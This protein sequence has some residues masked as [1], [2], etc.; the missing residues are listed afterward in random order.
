VSNHSII[1]SFNCSL[2]RNKIWLIIF[3]TSR[4]CDHIVLFSQIFYAPGINI[5][6]VTCC[7]A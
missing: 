3:F 2:Y 7:I 1:N 6:L 4:D 5:L